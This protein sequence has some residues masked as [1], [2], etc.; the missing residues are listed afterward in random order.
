MP[1]LAR[2]AVSTQSP[3]AQA[4]GRRRQC[5]QRPFAQRGHRLHRRGATVV[6]LLRDYVAQAQALER[7]PAF[8]NTLTSNC[9]TIVYELM[10]RVVPTL[11]LDYRLLLSG[12]LA[13]YAADV[14]GLTPGVAYARLHERGR[15]TLRAREAGDTPDFSRRIR[16]GIPGIPEGEVP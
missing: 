15:I 3:Q 2:S 9:T 4:A 6:T 14:G 16:E 12:Y 13:E 5:Q 1:P 7:A 10:R 8:Y 11:P